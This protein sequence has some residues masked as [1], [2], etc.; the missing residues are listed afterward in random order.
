MYGNKTP[1]LLF[2]F[3]F[4]RFFYGVSLIKHIF[5]LRVSIDRI[6]DT[7]SDDNNYYTYFFAIR[8]NTIN[9]GLAC[10]PAMEQ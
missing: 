7:Y 6:T 2:N 4:L 10:A 9:Y 3:F 1:L 5:D 8:K